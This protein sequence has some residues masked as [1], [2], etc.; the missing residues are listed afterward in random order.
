[1]NSRFLPFVLL[2]LLAGTSLADG[3]LLPNP[4]LLL[5]RDRYVQQECKVE[6]QQVKALRTLTDKID[7]HFFPIRSYAPSQA[8]GKV[9]KLI[10]QAK[11]GVKEIFR[12]VQRLRLAQITLR[13]QGLKS[14]L[15]D[16]VARFIDM[17]NNQR[18]ETTKLIQ[19]QDKDLAELSKQARAGKP[20]GA[21][22]KTAKQIRQ[23]TY[24]EL[25]AMLSP[26]QKSDFG[27]LLGKPIDMTKIY[28]DLRFKAPDFI[29]GN[30][31][32]DSKPLTMKQLRGKVVAL[33]FYAFG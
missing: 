29:R 19:A 12:P 4:Y 26:V 15:R 3:P 9:Q 28:Q 18:T 10:N 16:D 22:E 2:G 8:G 30:L 6:P 14:L 23:K 24:Q 20:R 21:L 5:I 17:S 25:M 7:P 13:C 11:S 1:M 33:H 32:I 31:W 27:R